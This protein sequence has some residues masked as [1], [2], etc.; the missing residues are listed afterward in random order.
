MRIDPID[1]IPAAVST[2]LPFPSDK[3]SG[4]LF[5]LVERGMCAARFFQD[6]DDAKVKVQI[7]RNDSLPS[8]K[9]VIIR[10]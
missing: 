7:V 2:F 4:S 6:G 5:I 1:S 3:I 9:Y 10:H 8:I